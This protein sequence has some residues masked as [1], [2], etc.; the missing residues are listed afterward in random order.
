MLVNWFFIKLTAVARAP[1]GWNRGEYLHECMCASVS[2]CVCCALIINL[3][4]HSGF[5]DLQFQLRA[6]EIDTLRVFVFV[7]VLGF[8]RQLAGGGGGMRRGRD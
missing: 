5:S 8:V 6:K 2:V 4:T 1:G 7:L 3:T